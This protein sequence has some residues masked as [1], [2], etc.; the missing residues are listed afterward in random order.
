[1]RI[2]FLGTPHFA[3]SVLD[4]LHPHYEIAGVFCQPDK[5]V[6]R[7]GILSQPPVKKKA[8]E[9][10]LPVFQP[11][12]VRKEEAIA[13]LKEL[14]PELIVVAAYGKILPEEV[15]DIP[16]Y[17]CLNVHASLLPAYR[18]A[19]PINWAIFNQDK[20]TGVTIMRMNEGMDTGDMISKSIIEIQPDDDAPALFLKLAVSGCELLLNTI[21][22]WVDGSLKAEPQDEADATYAPILSREDGRIDWS[23]PTAK[24]LAH[25]RAFTPWPGTFSTFRSK[26]VVLE[27]L[28]DTSTLFPKNDAQPGAVIEALKKE[29]IVVA[30]GDG[31]ILISRLKM[32]NKKSMAGSDFVNGYRPVPPELFS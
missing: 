27:E 20:E 13:Q 9:L 18:G 31:A 19:A 6:G 3:A 14:K 17:G 32:E 29:G 5:K 22:Q 4:A 11:H 25:K 10:E 7:K 30:T 16:P 2:V 8:L 23:W 24:I 12:S 26:K 21:P 1:M 28:S 15:L